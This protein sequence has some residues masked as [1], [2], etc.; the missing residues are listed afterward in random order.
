MDDQEA[1]EVV[2]VLATRSLACPS[3]G[4]DLR[5]NTTGS[6]PECGRRVTAADLAHAARPG[7]GVVA[8]RLLRAGFAAALVMTALFVFD[9]VRW[10]WHIP[11]SSF[12]PPGGRSMVAAALCAAASVAGAWGLH[13]WRRAGAGI[14][15]DDWVTP[16]IVWVLLIG[17]LAVYWKP[18]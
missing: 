18:L 4:Y 17:S 8:R 2:R 13:R 12:A 1:A 6:C 10:V 14:V 5:G 7:P 16:S 15:V 3:C 11:R 9:M